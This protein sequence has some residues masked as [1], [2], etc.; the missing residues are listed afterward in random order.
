MSWLNEDSTDSTSTS[1]GEDL[2]MKKVLCLDFDGVLNRYDSGW[3]GPRT[4][5]DPPVDGAIAF[6]EEFA[7]EHCDVPDELC[8][9]A[10]RGAWELHIYSSRSHYWFG[11]RAMK[12]WLVSVGLRRCFLE[13]IKFPNYKPPAT[14]SID[15]RALTFRGKFP[16]FTTI[17]T[18]IPWNKAKT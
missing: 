11:R 10:P 6:I 4:I 8:A 18:F 9:M 15:D 17:T 2:T 16:D 7:L 14:V 12:K 5:S 1:T 13:V 3:Q